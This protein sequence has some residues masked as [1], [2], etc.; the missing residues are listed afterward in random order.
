VS[1]FLE[2]KLVDMKIPQFTE[3]VHD[4]RVRNGQKGKIKGMEIAGQYAF[5]RSVSWLQGFGVAAN[6]TYVDANASRDT[7]TGATSCG[8]P[9]LSPQSY[10]GSVF[11]EDSKFQAR[12]SYNW[13]N[14]FAVDCGGGS[15]MPR[16]RAAYGQTDASMRYNLTP[17][18]ALYADA[19]NVGNTKVR[20]YGSNENQFL[21][22]ENDGR[23]FNFGVRMAF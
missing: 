5:D 10:N 16:N 7:D 19:I 18:L 1:N 21:M 8:Y 17:S 12:V 23:R 3:I 13:R 20:E 9:G 15:S 11:F 14:H 22:L 2:T 6:Y 4:T